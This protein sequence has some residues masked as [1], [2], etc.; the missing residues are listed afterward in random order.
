MI[1][2]ALSGGG[3]RGPLQVGA[4]KALV[5]SGVRPDFLVGTSAGALN[6][7]YLAAWGVDGSLEGLADVWRKVDKQAIYPGGWLSLLWR[8]VTGRQSLYPNEGF[9]ET[10]ATSL[11]R[12]DLTFAD[13]KI[14]CYV[15]TADLRTRRLFLFPDPGDRSAGVVD[16]VMASASI[17][18]LHPPIELGGR[19]L[20]DGGVVDNVPASVAMDQGA[21]TIYLINV[22]YDGEEEG[23]AQGLLAILSRTL[24]TFLAQSLFT[25]IE[26]AVARTDVDLHHIA[27]SAFQETSFS[28]FSQTDRMIEAGYQAAQAYLASPDPRRLPR[29]GRTE[30]GAPPGAIPYTPRRRSR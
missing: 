16:A 7:I 9:R 27:I 6:A 3:N 10:I 26:W 11:P 1:A 12:P 23:P 22:G 25:D 19:Q 13:L 28:D 15:T 30:R 14:P 20:V 2:F 17:P 8:V 21:S 4:L 18:V 5:E 24:G 29:E